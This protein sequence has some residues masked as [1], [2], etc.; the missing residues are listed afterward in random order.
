M[1][2]IF[3]KENGLVSHIVSYFQKDLYTDGD[4]AEGL[5]VKIVDT[6]TDPLEIINTW[7]W[8]GK[9][10]GTH[11]EKPNEPC[12]LW[13]STLFAYE[14]VAPEPFLTE[15]FIREEFRCIIFGF[16]INEKI[17]NNLDNV[18]VEIWVNTVDDINTAT[19]LDVTSYPVYS[20]NHIKHNTRYY[21]LK[22]VY[23]KIYYGE[24]YAFPVVTPIP[25]TSVDVA[26]NAFSIAASGVNDMEV[27]GEGLSSIKT[28]HAFSISNTNYEPTLFRITNSCKQIYAEGV[29]STK[30]YLMKINSEVSYDVLG[31]WSCS[32][33]NELPSF[34]FIQEVSSDET[35]TFAICWSASD[36]TVSI[37]NNT[38][39]FIGLVR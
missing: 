38:Y 37:S 24:T 31:E 15:T 27:F 36:E 23:D 7:H 12:Y 28:V 10:F 19:L 4:M 13:N 11:A 3:V 33:I 34:E 26:C 16:T 21:W 9:E 14:F 8:T 18:K 22:P 6:S 35:N 32:S 2:H 5:L 17:Y 30:W 29:K 1:S 25:L 20:H 39:S